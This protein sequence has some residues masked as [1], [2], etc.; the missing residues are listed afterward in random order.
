MSAF[1]HLCIQWNVDDDC[2]TELAVHY[3]RT[4]PDVEAEV[5]EVRH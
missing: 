4:K 3:G 5:Q 2:I 1:Y